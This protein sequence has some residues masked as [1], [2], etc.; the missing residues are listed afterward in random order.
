MGGD[1]V[2]LDRNSNADGRGKYALIKLREVPNLKQLHG[3]FL[4]KG[5][6]CVPPAHID[7]GDTPETEFFVIRLKDKFAPAALRAYSEAVLEFTWKLGSSKSGEDLLSLVEY[8]DEI[9]SLYD[10]SLRLKPEIPT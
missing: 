9:R 1:N 2:K 10:K 7:F 6:I 4:G 3:E 5:V 8:A